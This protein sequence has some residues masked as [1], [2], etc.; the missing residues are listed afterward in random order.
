VSVAGEAGAQP[1]RLLIVEDEEAI[2]LTLREVLQQESYDVEVAASAEEAEAMIRPGQFDLALLDLRVG[3]GSGLSVL[4]YLKQHSPNSVAIVLTGYGALETAI[5]A[6]R[7]GALDY[8]LKPCDIG[9]LKSAIARGLQ[10]GR[11]KQLATEAEQ[12]QAELARALRARDDFLAMAAHEL[13][14]PLSVVIGW[15]QYLQRALG[16]AEPH[17][18]REKLDV[19]VGQA[20][21]LARL[22]EDFIDVVRIQN[23][24]LELSLETLDLR[25]VASRAVRDAQRAYPNHRYSLDVPAEP[26]WAQVDPARLGQVIGDVLDNAAKFSPQGGTVTVRVDS[27]AGMARVQ[28]RDEGIGIAAE[29]LD[30]IFQRFYQVDQDVMSRRFGGIGVGLFVGRALVEAHGGRLQ[31]DSAG[32]GKGSVFTISLPVGEPAGVPSKGKQ[33]VAAAPER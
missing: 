4:S 17:D 26:V 20:R 6:M 30:Q 31:A 15:A 7:D 8:L 9:E 24:S 3:E 22:V 21:R 19:L 13:R 33:G 2:A 32:L 29:E 10:E 11:R 28:V 18:A 14:T 25:N 12:A 16:Q 1:A 23:R 5:Q 27:E